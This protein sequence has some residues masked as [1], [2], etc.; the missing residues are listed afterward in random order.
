[1]KPASSNRPGFP[2]RMPERGTTLS[3]TKTIADNAIFT[4]AKGST[5]V[6]TTMSK[7]GSS[8][9]GL[10]SVAVRARMVQKLASQ[11]LQDSRVLA[12]MNEL[13]YVPAG[14]RIPATGTKVLGLLMESLSR[15][16]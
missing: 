5:Y 10:D 14:R 4:E 1:M 6:L 3:A 15:Q 7:P 16:A 8:G 13:G 9:V 2:L 11:G 12:A